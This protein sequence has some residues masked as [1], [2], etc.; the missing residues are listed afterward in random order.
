MIAQEDLIAYCAGTL[1]PGNLAR[2]ESELA[3]D[4]S[5]QKQL[6]DQQL[7]D[8]ALGVIL[9][10]SAGDER[11]KQSV[12]AVARGI[13]I[14][15]FRAGVLAETLQRKEP[16]RPSHAPTTPLWREA[17]TRILGRAIWMR[18]SMVLALAVAVVVATLGI[19]HYW[20]AP[21]QPEIGAFGGVSGNPTIRRQGA[22]S[23]LR[24][25]QSSR[26]RLGDF[27]QTGDAD[28]AEIQF[29]DGT[30]VRLG[31]NT[32]VNISNLKSQISDDKSA[33]G[34]PQE[35]K[36]GTGQLWLK[37]TKA[38]NPAPFA[39]STPV[40]TATVKG[41]EF[42]LTLR[43][44]ST[45]SPVLSTIS[46]ARSGQPSAIGHPPSAVEAVLMVK[47][48]VVEFA[49]SFGTVQATAMTESSAQL[50]QA[51]TAPKRVQTLGVFQL[52]GS[53]RWIVTTAP[54][55]RGEAMQRLVIA[56]Q[57]GVPVS[58]IVHMASAVPGPQLSNKAMGEL[59]T[60]TTLALADSKQKSALEKLGAGRLRAAAQNNLGVICEME[61][62]LDQAIPAYQK[63]CQNDPYVSLYH[64]NLALA[65]RK[66][67]NFERTAEELE[68]AVRLAP[69]SVEALDRLADAYSLLGRDSVA[70]AA[71]EAASNLDSKAHGPWEVKAQL[72]L[73]Q[74]RDDEA[75]A[76]ALKAVEL[77]P[78][79]GVACGLLAEVYHDEGQLGEAEKYFRKA[80]S[81]QPE[82]AALRL[83]LG[84]V[85]RDRHRL[86]EAEQSYREAITLR[87]DFA[88]A[89][90]NLGDVLLQQR[91]SEP[92]LQA[93]RKAVALDPED[94]NAC[95]DLADACLKQRQFGEA[96]KAY[97]RAL[98]LS[99]DDA[100]AYY[101]LGE[102]Y[103]TR[104][105]AT[106]AERMYRRAIELKPD[107]AE[108]Q[109]GL[110]IIYFERGQFDEAEKRYRKAI[111]LDPAN[112][113]AYHDLGE[114]YSQGRGN[115][116]Q[117][118]Q[119][120]RKAIE[121]AP[122]D[123]A[124]YSGLG[125]LL[126]GRGN[127]AE[128]E[129][130]LRR[131][132]ALDP[133]SSAFHNNLGQICRGQGNIDEAERH[134]RK[135]LELDPTSVGVY[136]NLAIVQKMR[137]QPAEGEKTLRSVLERAPASAKL[138]ILVTLADACSDQGKLEEAEKIY[139]QALALAPDAPYAWNSLAWFLADHR[140]K[141][142]EALEL[143]TRAVKATPD[144]PNNLDTLGWVHFQRAELAEAEA[145][146]KRALQ[147]AGENSPASE[148]GEHLKKVREK[149]GA[150][151]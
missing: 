118:E 122:N 149:K 11:V 72:L 58:G 34:R 112:S 20:P 18:P 113:S 71:A 35:L 7:I 65:L 56:A 77:E 127:L 99:P 102:V 86:A 73:K 89:Y 15:H 116:T 3:V 59:T 151:R 42:G 27:I 33:L 135:A 13:S 94:A 141:L 44:A 28:K 40:A 131:A 52:S 115:L 123:G 96:E 9:G 98:E 31:F 68:L 48:G 19:F 101:G 83:N 45:N 50:R 61:D 105:Q 37:V 47:D 138:P 134:Y 150:A 22:H 81:L 74:G 84:N 78:Q 32:T 53:H 60:A 6:A 111:E 144:D 70:L 91:Q 124:P 117:A 29:M 95:R 142:D 107:Y 5:A 79:C 80:I 26:V 55:N 62:Q 106:Q 125:V 14:E 39:V 49:N 128:A 63:A 51:P 87:S 121:L 120:Y 92:A 103:R 1:D 104:G 41:T 126:A 85:L 110:G 36:L 147:L 17:L 12:L 114:L 66:I 108:P 143:S 119:F 129:K 97:R 25:N 21:L 23:A 148:I 57:S 10:G 109:T 16:S 69:R 76:A 137:G 132:V 146:L 82:H 30:T 133:D 67:G 54:L 130:L 38:T 136:C 100:V 43:N 75:L 140:L 93:L 8:Q 2:F 24:A 46:A 90:R 145:T 64:Y 139:R 88:L 4:R